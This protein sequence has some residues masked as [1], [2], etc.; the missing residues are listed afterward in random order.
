MIADEACRAQA[1]RLEGVD[2][3]FYEEIVS[4][5]VDDSVLQAIRARMVDT[6]PVYTLFT[7]GST[8]LPKG[9][10]LSYMSSLYKAVVTATCYHTTEHVKYLCS[11]PIYHIAGMVFMH[12]HVYLGATMYMIT[13]IEPE[14]IMQLVDKYRCDYWYGSALMNKAIIEHPDVGKYDLSSLRQTV[15]TSFGIQLTA[16]MA[17]QW[18]E[19][20]KGG[21]LVEWAYGMTESHTMDTGTPV[22]RP[23]YGS[24][25]MP[26]I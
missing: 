2:V 18:A 9:A 12:S 15:T 24:C 16:E 10:M 5:L 7:S 21:T 13:K 3:C 1:V 17:E 4:T 19:I 26:V 25:G 14:V 22:G 6:D 20:T 11:Q 8:G 23:K